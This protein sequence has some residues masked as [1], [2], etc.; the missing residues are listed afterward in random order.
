MQPNKTNLGFLG[1]NFQYKLIHQ[2]MENQT[3]FED[4]CSIIDQNMF[5]DPN[6][7]TIVGVLKNYYE[8]YNIVSDYDN[9]GIELRDLSRSEKEKET[10]LAVLEKVKN[11]G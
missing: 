4:L 5:T 9:V 1:E 7:K 10:Y 3:F 11:N 6:L 2:F 8:K